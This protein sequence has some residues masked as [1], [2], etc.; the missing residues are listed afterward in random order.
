M[1]KVIFKIIFS[2]TTDAKTTAKSL[3]QLAD[4]LNIDHFSAEGT[5]SQATYENLFETKLEYKTK[6]IEH[7]GEEYEKTWWEEE[8]PATVPKSLSKEIVKIELVPPGTDYAHILAE[9]LS[10]VR[11]KGYNYIKD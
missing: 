8:K 11:G 1:D 2:E 5:T 3:E 6:I 9:N 10:K 7:K 4:D